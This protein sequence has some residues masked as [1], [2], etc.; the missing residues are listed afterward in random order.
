MDDGP[1]SPLVMRE[2]D[3]ETEVVYQNAL[4]TS[5]GDVLHASEEEACLEEEEEEPYQKHLVEAIAFSAASDC[6]VPP[7]APPPLTEPGSLVLR[8]ELY[9]WDGLMCEWISAPPVWLGATRE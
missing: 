2:K 3:Q 8:P 1:L 7:L 9:A 4:V 6:V 5:V